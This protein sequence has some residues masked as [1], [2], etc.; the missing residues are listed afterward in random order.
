MTTKLQITAFF[1]FI[2]SM[3][4]YAQ[5]DAKYNHYM[6]NGL[7]LNPAYAA[8]TETGNAM[9]LYRNQWGKFDNTAGPKS[10]YATAHHPV[11]LLKGGVGL[12]ITNDEIWKDKFTN[13][14]FT[15]AYKRALK[16]GNLSIGTTLG[17][18][19]ATIGSGYNPTQP[20]DPGVPQAEFTDM[21]F[22]AAIGA[23]YTAP[24]WYAGASVHIALGKYTPE[25]GLYS[26][27]IRPHL[28]ITGG[29]NY[30]LN[31]NLMLMPSVLIKSDFGTVQTDL[32]VLALYKDRFW[33]GLAYTSGD[34]IVPMVGM[35][36]NDKV[37]AGYAYNAN[38][39][40]LQ[41]FGGSTH[42]VFVGY[43]FLIK[44]PE[45]QQNIIRSPRF[46]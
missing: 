14:Q 39:S 4:A 12:V 27:T 30:T 44:I 17:L 1:A 45:K 22:D 19:Q 5:Q 15:Y 35:K 43:D 40:G 3:T 32:T 9:V 13:V 46:L 2:L 42:E 33:G 10:L 16:T 34:G 8:A 23:Y 28:Y 11:P 6:F 26:Q 21:G 31:E 24:K 36:I 29:Y 41:R 38:L 37:K 20:G 25:T 18:H 7:A